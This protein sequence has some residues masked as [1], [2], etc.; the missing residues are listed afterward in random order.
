MDEQ[1]LLIASGLGLVVGLFIMYYI[2]HNA[3]RSALKE[4]DLYLRTMYRMQVKKM[5]DFG[6]TE[7]DISILK[8]DDDETFW[9]KLKDKK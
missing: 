2:I 8:N 3:V 9:S 5:I 6:Y 1:T 7:E 4:Q